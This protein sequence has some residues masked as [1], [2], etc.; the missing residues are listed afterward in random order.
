V[1]AYFETVK[2]SEILDLQ[3]NPIKHFYIRSQDTHRVFYCFKISQHKTLN[4][5]SFYW[6]NNTHLFKRD[7]LVD[8]KAAMIIVAKY[9]GKTSYLLFT[10]RIVGN[11]LNEKN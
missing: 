11:A 7:K 6:K 8:A 9:H 10:N 5:D 1:L 2:L 4:T 3:Q